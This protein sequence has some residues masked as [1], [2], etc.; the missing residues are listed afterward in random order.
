MNTIRFTG[1]RVTGF[2][3]MRH[4][5]FVKETGAVHFDNV[6]IHIKIRNVMMKL[7]GS[8][9]RGR[10]AVFAYDAAIAGFCI[11]DL[12]QKARMGLDTEPFQACIPYLFG[13]GGKQ[14]GSSRPDDADAFHDEIPRVHMKCG[15]AVLNADDDVECMGLKA[16]DLGVHV[17]DISIAVTGK[18]FPGECQA[19][20]RC[21]DAYDGSGLLTE[22]VE[23]TAVTAA[24]FQ[25]NVL[26]IQS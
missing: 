12:S 7:F 8:Y 11:V 9:R 6:Q 13:V 21:V 25:D 19:F 20:Q 16:R 15:D 1:N 3:R 17:K 24:E 22:S 2:S 18:T 14:H 5:Y 26:P 23:Y 10:E 4:G